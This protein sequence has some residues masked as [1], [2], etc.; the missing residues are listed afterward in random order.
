MGARVF[1][2][3]D[4]GEIEA[5]LSAAFAPAPNVELRGLD[6]LVFLTVV[7]VVADPSTEI[8]RAAVQAKQPDLEGLE[9]GEEVGIR[10]DE[11][12]RAL[13]VA[14]LRALCA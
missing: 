8:T 13:R 3:E 10:D 6:V 12:T 9:I 7:D 4:P 5:R 2:A 11:R 1:R 14:V